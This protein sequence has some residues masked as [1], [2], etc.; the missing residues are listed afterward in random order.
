MARKSIVSAVAMWREK[1]ANVT[2][3]GVEGRWEIS[4]SAC[5]LRAEEGRYR[6]DGERKD[7]CESQNA[8]RVAYIADE[9]AA[10]ARS[11]SAWA[12]IVRRD[13]PR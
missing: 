12:I 10:K 8:M 1:S 7:W 4:C 2:R 3:V 11:T 5:M 6:K 13:G 9:H